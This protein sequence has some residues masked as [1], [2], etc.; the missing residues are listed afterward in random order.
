MVDSSLGKSHGARS[1]HRGALSVTV[2][3]MDEQTLIDTV[4]N[5]QNRDI[6]RKNVYFVDLAL[7]LQ[8]LTPPAT[9][10]SFPWPPDDRASL[11]PQTGDTQAIKVRWT[12]NAAAV[13]Q[14]ATARTSI[15]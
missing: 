15:R 2:D 7:D 6:L 8:V 9:R 4:P 12:Q 3:L 1:P 11:S 10:A 13:R 5:N 14:L